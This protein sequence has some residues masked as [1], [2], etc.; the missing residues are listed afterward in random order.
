MPLHYTAWANA[1]DVAEWLV[2]QGADV[3]AKDNGGS[4]PLD[5]AITNGN[6]EMQAMLR[7]HGGRCNT[8]C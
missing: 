8:E 3:N 4:T 5:R 1:L 7:R 2:G 6:D